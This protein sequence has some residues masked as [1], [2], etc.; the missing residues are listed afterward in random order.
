MGRSPDHKGVVVGD[1]SQVEEVVVGDHRLEVEGEEVA[2][3]PCLEE[4]EE[5]VDIHQGEEEEGE[6]GE[7]VEVQPP[8]V[9]V[10]VVGAL[11]FQQ[12]LVRPQPVTAGYGSDPP[13]L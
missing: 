12:L 5:E 3:R 8:L 11:Q 6:A 10:V 9:W 13:I 4:V 1:H 2:Y 7:G